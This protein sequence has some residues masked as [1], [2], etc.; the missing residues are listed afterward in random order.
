M[1]ENQ[2][3]IVIDYYTD[4]L[5]VWAYFGQIKVDELKREFGERIELHYKFI[6]LFGCCET[7]IGEGWEEGGYEGYSRHV[8][9]LATNFPHVEIHPRI[10]LDARPASSLPVHLVLKAVQLLER[11]DE[12]PTGEH[13]EKTLFETLVWNLRLGFFRDLENIADK[14][15]LHRHLEQLNIP[16]EAVEREIAN[17]NAFAEMALDIEEHKERM[18]EGSPTFLMNEGRQRLYGNV[19][20]RA[21]AANVQELLERKLDIPDWC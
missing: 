3:P 2:S 17:G 1:T 6:P 12:L 8:L 9:E 13:G 19:G 4:A 5:C 11:R 10:W 20:Y 15:V 16:V 18:I 14:A 7:R 21:I